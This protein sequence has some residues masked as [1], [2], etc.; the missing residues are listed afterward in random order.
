MDWN[1]GFS[2]RIYAWVVDPITWRDTEQIDILSGEI[3]RTMDELMQSAT[4]QVKRDLGERWIR[5]YLEA[6]QESGSASR[7]ALFTGLTSCPERK[8]DGAHVSYAVECYSVLKLAADI[9][10]PRGYYA[11]LGLNAARLAAELLKIGAIPISIEEE[12]KAPSLSNAI[13]ADDG[14]TNLSMAR[15]IVAAI[16][17]EIGISGDGSVI[18]RA[19]KN[20]KVAS[21]DAVGNDVV[22][23]SVKDK[24]DWFDCPN[25]FRAVSGDTVAIARDDSEGLLSIKSRGREIWTEEDDCDLIGGE[26]LAEYASRRLKEE[27]SPARSLSYT[28]RFNPNVFPGDVVR[29]HYPGHG[30][31]GLFTVIEQKITLGGGCQTEEEVESA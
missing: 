17:W 13:V 14:E 23:L 31:D 19:S 30:I 5:I 11:P 22:G 1:H 20:G 29:I 26:S 18:I 28:R 16:G 25:V 27:Q 12:A 15:R 21:F 24:K 4:V 3:S 6:K 2:S 9:L 7:I 8:L 10:L